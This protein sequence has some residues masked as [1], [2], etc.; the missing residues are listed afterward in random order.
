MSLLEPVYHWAKGDPWSK[1]IESYKSDFEGNLI[2]NILR[3]INI[4]RNIELIARLTKNTELLDKIEGYQEKMI[5]GMVV[6]ES[7]FIH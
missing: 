6:P 5:R 4:I 2:Q 3:I 7:L 1:V